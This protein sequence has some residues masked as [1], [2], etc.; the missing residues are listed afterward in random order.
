M[1]T[2]QIRNLLRRVQGTEY[3]KLCSPIPSEGSS[4]SF[5]SG[6]FAYSAIL[7][8]MSSE[9]KIAAISHFFNKI[10]EILSRL[11]QHPRFFFFLTSDVLFQHPRFFFFLTSDVL[12]QLQVDSSLEG[13][14]AAELSISE[15]FSQGGNSILNSKALEG[16]LQVGFH[17]HFFVPYRGDF[18]EICSTVS[19]HG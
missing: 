16:Q 10:F 13:C 4:R 12:F 5:R 6:K 18:I 9:F 19:S 3:L 17:Q 1:Q 15:I 8:Q 7:M 11:R 14:N 2:R